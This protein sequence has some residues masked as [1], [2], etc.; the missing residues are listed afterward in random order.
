MYRESYKVESYF[1]PD[2]LKKVAG[3][4]LLIV[5]S[6]YDATGTGPMKARIETFIETIRR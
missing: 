5:E 3:F 4:P 6:K 2:I 1:L